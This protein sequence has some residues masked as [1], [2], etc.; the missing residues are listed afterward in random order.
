MERLVEK[1]DA[2]EVKEKFDEHNLTV[3]ERRICQLFRSAVLNRP[4]NDPC[5]F[6]SLYEFFVF[7]KSQVAAESFQELMNN[8]KG[9]MIQSM[10]KRHTSTVDLGKDRTEARKLFPLRKL[11]YIECL[12]STFGQLMNHFKDEEQR[13][14]LRKD[15]IGTLTDVDRLMEQRKLELA[16]EDSTDTLKE[17]IRS[18]FP[19]EEMDEETR[20]LFSQTRA[21]RETYEQIQDR[22]REMAFQQ[23]PVTAGAKFGRRAGL[24]NPDNPNAQ[25]IQEFRAQEE[26]KQR[27]KKEI[28]T[29][30]ARAKKST[31]CA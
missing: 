25:L 17:L 20:K 31:S 13:Q 27:T 2:I 16:M 22:M 6:L 18:H 26:A 4:R 5:N 1:L 19:P 12:P 3:S 24:A 15:A 29:L 14:K 21:S 10:R 28:R 9:S 11:K 30:I 7:S 23:R 8:I